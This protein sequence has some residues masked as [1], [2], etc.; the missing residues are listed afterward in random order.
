LCNLILLVICGKEQL[1]EEHYMANLKTLDINGED[2]LSKISDIYYKAVFAENLP[3]NCNLNDLR[4]EGIYYIQNGNI[5]DTI[6]NCPSSYGGRIEVKRIHPSI[7]RCVQEYYA[8]ATTNV[9]YFRTY[10]SKGWTEWETI[11]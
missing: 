4:A 2:I 6:A 1:R 8:N 7:D 5:A 3:E 9:K 10:N 11:I